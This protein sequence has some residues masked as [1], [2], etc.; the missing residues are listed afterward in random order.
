MALLETWQLRLPRL[1]CVNRSSEVYSFPLLPRYSNMKLFHQLF[2]LLFKVSHSFFLLK[3]LLHLLFSVVVV[4]MLDVCYELFFLRSA[5]LKCQLFFLFNSWCQDFLF[6]YCLHLLDLKLLLDLDLSLFGFMSRFLDLL[7]LIKLYLGLDILILPLHHC[8]SD[9]HFFQLL[10]PFYLLLIS[11][12]FHLH[13][14]WIYTLT[15]SN[16]SLLLIITDLV[17]CNLSTRLYDLSSCRFKVL[18]LL[19]IS[20]IC[21]HD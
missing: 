14:H 21:I 16:V 12:F 20:W 15:W 4:L 8:Y 19:C 9:L 11:M 6:L 5:S 10:L 18:I 7:Y 17:L 2:F 1:S 13:T 3:D